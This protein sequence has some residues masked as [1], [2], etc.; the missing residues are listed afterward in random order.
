MLGP[1]KLSEI[2]DELR[3]ALGMSDQD[4]RTWLDQQIAERPL[5]AA[6]RSKVLEDLLWVRDLLQSTVSK[7]RRKAKEP[8]AKSTPATR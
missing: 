7:P 1:K 2:R 5:K 3:Q 4:L 8:R 6:G